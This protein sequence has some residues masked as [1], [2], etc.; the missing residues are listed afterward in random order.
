[1]GSLDSLPWLPWQLAVV[2][3]LELLPLPLTTPLYS[4]QTFLVIPHELLMVA[5]SP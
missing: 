5:V 2:S 1:V 4:W 3:T